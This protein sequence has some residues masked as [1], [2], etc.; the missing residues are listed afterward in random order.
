MPPEAAGV[1]CS[2][3]GSRRAPLWGRQGPRAASSRGQPSD[4]C[5]Q[6]PPVPPARTAPTTDGTQSHRQ[7]GSCFLRATL[8]P[9][10]GTRRQENATLKNTYLGPILSRAG[11][12]RSELQRVRGG[13]LRSQVLTAAAPNP[14]A[15]A[16]T[17]PA[18][19]PSSGSS[20]SR[21][22]G[23]GHP[24]L[25]LQLAER[26]GM[27]LAP[28]PNLPPSLPLRFPTDPTSRPSP[29]RAVL[30]VNSTRDGRRVRQREQGRGWN[31]GCDTQE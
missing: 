16:G 18:A 23:T 10:R 6:R 9:Q 8:I 24:G 14:P 28:S 3:Q 27:S 13:G 19:S 11:V 30:L 2:T 12:H 31:N 17:A 25:P 7:C 4:H 15:G 5:I 20:Q 21:Q 1:D 26:S 22:Q 29:T